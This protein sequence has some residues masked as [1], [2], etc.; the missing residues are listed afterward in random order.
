MDW[1]NGCSLQILSFHFPEKRNKFSFHRI[2]YAHCSWFSYV[3]SMLSALQDLP[4][5][6]NYPKNLI[7]NNALLSVSCG[8]KNKH[9]WMHLRHIY[10]H[11]LHNYILYTSMYSISH[12]KG[13]SFFYTSTL[14]LVEVVPNYINYVLVVGFTE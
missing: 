6:I 12:W 3:A 4:K 11:L 14:E 8:S 10:R 9:H 7:K 5:V 2:L 13:E 1:L